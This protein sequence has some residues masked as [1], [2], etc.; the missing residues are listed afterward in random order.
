MVNQIEMHPGL[1]NTDLLQYCKKHNIIVQAYSPLGSGKIQGNEVLSEIAI[2]HNKSPSQIALRWCVQK[3]VIPL[4]KSTNEGRIKE[5]INIF[6]F[7]LSFKEMKQI[8]GMKQERFF[9]D[10][11]LGK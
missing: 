3:G 4:P 9:P 11:L 6:D 8:D 2:S 5:N 1:N 10:P 7:T